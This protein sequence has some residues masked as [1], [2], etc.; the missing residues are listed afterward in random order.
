MGD[1]PN[2]KRS[3]SFAEPLLIV[4]EQKN[5]SQ[6]HIYQ[7]VFDFQPI[8]RDSNR[9][10]KST[11]RI[12][13]LDSENIIRSSTNSSTNFNDSNYLSYSNRSKSKSIESKD[14]ENIWKRREIVFVDGSQNFREAIF[15][16]QT[17]K[18]P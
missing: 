5:N 16:Q 7:N 14:F 12:D 6:D 8:L 9:K 18:R 17:M 15:H 3:K 10:S 4:D 2:L 1:R 11:G 13:S